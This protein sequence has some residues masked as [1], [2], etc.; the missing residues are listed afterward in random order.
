MSGAQNWFPGHMNKTL[1]EIEQLI[2]AV[3]VVVEVIDARAPYS[4]QNPLFRNLLK[5]KVVVYVISKIDLANPLATKEWMEHFQEQGDSFLLVEKTSQNLTDQLVGIINQVTAKT[6]KKQH[7]KGIVNPQ[8]NALIIGLP[9]VG[10]STFINKIVKDKRVKAGNKPG[11]TRGLQRIVLT[12]NITLIDTPGIMPSKI[13]NESIATNLVLI[14]AVKEDVFPRE[15]MAARAMR[16]VFNN[17]PDKV[18]EVY[19]TRLNF[20]PPIEIKD[21]YRIFEKIAKKNKW[22]LLEDVYDVERVMK[23]F[24]RDVQNGKLG[25]ISYET[26]E[27]IAQLEV[28]PNKEEPDQV[29]NKSDVSSE[30]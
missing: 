21:T 10:K 7:Q 13:P 5:N 23:T 16:Y 22:V 8:L 24:L 29:E 12:K 4:S 2:T 17:Y 25:R 14:N 6:R 20:L 3:D 1:K 11:L 18:K 28:N 15:R 30:W 26:P 27:L 9:N 19:Q